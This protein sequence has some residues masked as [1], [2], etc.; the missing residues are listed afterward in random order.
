MYAFS[1][2]QIFVIFFILGICVGVIFDLFRAVRK[3]F[4][5]SDFV[6]YIEDIIFMA[7]S[8]ILVVNN[9]IIINNGEIR[10]YII[11]SLFFGMIFYFFTISKLCVIIFKYVIEFF[12]KIIFLPF[13]L[14]NAIKKKKDLKK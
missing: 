9:L 11:L 1:Q 7:I 8:G 13:F 14:K 12:K 6:T 4:N 10:F 2:G 5:T 3:V